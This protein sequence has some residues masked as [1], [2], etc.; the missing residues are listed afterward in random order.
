MRQHGR[1]AC[2]WNGQARHLWNGLVAACPRNGQVSLNAEV[3]HRLPMEWTGLIKC[4]SS[5]SPVSGMDRRRAL[6]VI[7]VEATRPK[8][9]TS[10]SARWLTSR[11]VGHMAALG[12]RLG[13]SGSVYDK[14]RTR[15]G[16]GPPPVLD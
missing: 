16:S 15:V 8:G 11:V 14:V 12:L 13:G 2:Q 3:T 9:L 10:G 7:N 4:R 6:S 5:T 1:T